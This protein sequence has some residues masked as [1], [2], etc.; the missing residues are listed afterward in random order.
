MTNQCQEKKA[1]AKQGLKWYY[2]ENFISPIE[3]CNISKTS[4]SVSLGFQKRET[5]ETQ[6]F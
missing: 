6:V 5:F 3:V 1:K 2:D 4:A